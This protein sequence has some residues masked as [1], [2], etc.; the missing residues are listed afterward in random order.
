MPRT[1]FT[2]RNLEADGGGADERYGQP[3]FETIPLPSDAA[4]V[5]R[6]PCAPDPTGAWWGL[7]DSTW[8]TVALDADGDGADDLLYVRSVRGADRLALRH[9]GYLPRTDRS[10]GDSSVLSRT[11]DVVFLPDRPDRDLDAI[12]RNLEWADSLDWNTDGRDD[13]VLMVAAEGEPL[14]EVIVGLATSSAR[15]RIESTGLFIPATLA[16]SEFDDGSVRGGLVGT[17]VRRRLELVDLNGDGRKDVLACLN[18][19]E[20]NDR[21]FDGRE[22][23]QTVQ[24]RWWYAL[25]TSEGMIGTPTASGR[26][27]LSASA[28]ETAC[29]FEYWGLE[30]STGTPMEIGPDFPHYDFAPRV[31]DS[32]G[33]GREELLIAPPFFTDAVGVPAA[34]REARLVA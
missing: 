10:L 32:D 11:T 5:R 21:Y 19:A 22:N 4:L 31:L 24:G 13:L 16:T 30:R 8:P 2:W 34:S 9:G 17:A 15:F 18:G 27:R 3:A 6:I 14:W 23:V 1:T 7:C 12:V 20:I 25:R 26:R 33:D 28:I 29:G